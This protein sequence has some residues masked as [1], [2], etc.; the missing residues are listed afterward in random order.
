MLSC[1]NRFPRHGP[2]NRPSRTPAC[3][4][5]HLPAWGAVVSLLGAALVPA[6]AAALDPERPIARHSLD[7]W[8]TADGLPRN[9]VEAVVQTAEGELWF[10]TSAGLARLE[11]DHFGVWSA[12]S[13][14]GIASLP[15]T[16]LEEDAEPGVLWLGLETGGLLRFDTRS[17]DHRLLREPDGLCGDAVTALRRDADG[18]LWIGTRTAQVCRYLDGEFQ[19][20]PVAGPEARSVFDIAVDGAGGVYFA[21]GSGGLLY[22]PRPNAPVRALP[23][24]PEPATAVLVDE[25]G[26]VYA[27]TASAGVFRFHWDEGRF[28]A[29]GTGILGQLRVRCLRITG[30]GT[31]WVGTTSQGVYRLRLGRN[32]EVLAVDHLDAPLVTDLLEDQEGSLWITTQGEGVLRLADLPL[33]TI[34]RRH[35]LTEEKVWSLLPLGDG[36]VLVGTAGGGIYRMDGD[37]VQPWSP[38]AALPHDAIVLSLA[39]DTRGAVWASVY[40]HGVA[41]IEPRGV[42]LFGPAEGLASD[43]PSVLLAA[44]DGRILVGH[45]S[46][47]V[48]VLAD[49][50]VAPL[51]GTAGLAQAAIT[52]LLEDDGGRLWIG[53]QGAGL[54]I[55]QEGRSTWITTAE[56]LADDGVSSLYQAGDGALWVATA[57]GLSRLRQDSVVNVGRAQGLPAGAVYDLLQERG[58]S[59]WLSTDVGIVRIERESIDSLVAGGGGRLVARTFGTA[60]G[61]LTSECNGGTQS[62]MAKDAEGVIYVATTRGVAVVEPTREFAVPAAPRVIVT[63][64]WAGR[65]RRVLPQEGAVPTLGRGPTDIAVEFL[66]T[67]YLRPE[68]VAYRYRLEGQAGG[69]L[70]VGDERVARFPQLGPGR[71]RFEVQAR[72]GGDWGE[73]AALPF[74]IKGRPWR[75]PWPW[76]ALLFAAGGI[77]LARVVRSATAQTRRQR[78]LES[79]LEAKAKELRDAALVDPLTGLRNRRFVTEV[80]LPE[81]A[82]FMSRRAQT[83]RSGTRR[84]TI[85]EAGVFGIFLFDIDHFKDIN[86]TLGHEAGDRMLQQFSYLLRRSVRLEDFVIRWGGEEFLVILRFSDRDHLDTYARRVREQVEQTTFLVAAAAG[87]SLKKTTSI[88]YISMPF[89]D[90]NPELLE[91]EQALQL[92]DEALYKAKEGGRNRAVRVVSTGQVPEGAD[93]KQ[94]VRSVDWAIEHGFA[95]IEVYGSGS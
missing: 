9:T 77:V 78:E 49:D 42:R 2:V 83:L 52:A 84:R 65:S 15:A 64:L 40:D 76:A 46:G 81:V 31:L 7:H 55:L 87:G 73:S 56:G 54:A 19:P 1:G 92:A 8:T 32:D 21:A 36:S 91:F 37:V 72:R 5:S 93:L 29:V 86:D 59:F 95:R 10:A 16:A 71:Y 14:P 12:D 82:A 69:W 23:G 89:F 47:A 34:S 85:A 66:A 58:G 75:S 88:G 62:N 4:P 44:R 57:S 48:D 3:D 61:M 13:F 38:A 28:V 90:E 33:S 17:G 24:L 60:E 22:A 18:G 41:R 30:A 45:F 74:R 35:G 68:G 39:L 11:G 27:G 53:T 67:S 43:H 6:R 26:A 25:R 79:A 51:E 94:M 50:E 63:G 70:E 20:L 80:V